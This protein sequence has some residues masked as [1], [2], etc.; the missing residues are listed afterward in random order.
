MAQGAD[1]Y[2]KYQ[3]YFF[4]YL[5]VICELLIIIVERDDA[6][7]ELLALNV[8]IPDRDEVQGFGDVRRQTFG[9][10]DLEFQGHGAFDGE[11]I[12]GR[13][14]GYRRSVRILRQR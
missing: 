8:L 3:V 7:A 6:E 5:A 14:F 13:T 2:K 9:A 4:L 12:D 11:R 10:H 1:H